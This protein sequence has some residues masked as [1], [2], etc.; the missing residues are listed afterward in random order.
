MLANTANRVVTIALFVIG[1]APSMAFFLLVLGPHGLYENL[2]SA[3][4]ATETKSARL[5]FEKYSKYILVF[6][7]IFF[8]F[9]WFVFLLF[10]DRD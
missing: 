2:D 7:A 1:G 10:Q 6:Q 4:L 3:E 9:A 8:T 5:Q